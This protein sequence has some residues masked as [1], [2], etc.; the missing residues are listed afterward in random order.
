MVSKIFDTF[1]RDR[2]TE[3]P[4][5]VVIKALSPKLE[6]I[7]THKAVIYFDINQTDYKKRLAPSNNH[8]NKLKRL[9]QVPGTKY[10]E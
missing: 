4:T 9:L 6:N 5:K 7:E 3:Q 10:V 1:F 2:Q 8:I